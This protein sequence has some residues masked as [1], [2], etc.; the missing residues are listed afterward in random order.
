M[1]VIASAA[2][3]ASVKVWP[4]ASPAPGR[5]SAERP[6][7]GRTLLGRFLPEDGPS[8][9]TVLRRHGRDAARPS[10][11]PP[12]RPQ[13]RRTATPW[14][15]PTNRRAYSPRQSARWPWCPVTTA[16]FHEEEQD[17][18]DGTLDAKRASP[19]AAS[20]Y[21]L[22]W[23]VTTCR[24]PS[25]RRRAWWEGCRTL[26]RECRNPCPARSPLIRRR[27]EPADLSRSLSSRPRASRALSGRSRA[28]RACRSRMWRP[29]A[30]SSQSSRGASLRPDR[31]RPRSSSG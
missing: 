14:P 3:A 7:S 28:C 8:A 1:R 30:Q 17:S 21:S 18:I 22:A 4:R 12:G 11:E 2:P 10:R 15:M 23:R 16:Q 19:H 9:R 31:S 6:S 25:S 20:G 5:P 27:A 26:R 29:D 24:S 13:I